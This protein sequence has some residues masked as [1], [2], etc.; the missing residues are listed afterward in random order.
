MNSAPSLGW[1]RGF[2]NF[3][4]ILPLEWWDE[5]RIMFDCAKDMGRQTVVR[6]RSRNRRWVWVRC[7]GLECGVLCKVL[8]CRDLWERGAGIRLRKSWARARDV[9]MGVVCEEGLGV[10]GVVGRRGAGTGS[11]R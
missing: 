6:A 3:G 5:G 4:G 8:V 11:G 10:E 9:R 7:T 1:E 2:G